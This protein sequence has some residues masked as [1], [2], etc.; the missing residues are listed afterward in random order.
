MAEGNDDAGFDGVGGELDGALIL[1]SDGD[2]LYQA[3]GGVL[4]LVE[5]LHGRRGQVRGVLGTLVLLGKE[6]AL[7]EDALDAGVRRIVA[8][9]DVLGDGGAGALELLGAGGERG[10]QVAGHAV[11]EDAAGN[12]RDALGLAIHDVGTVKAMDMRVDVAGGDLMTGVVD[13]LAVGLLGH[14]LAEHAVLDHQVAATRNAGGQ[15][16]GIGFNCIRA[17]VYS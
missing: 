16:E 12:R 9:L 14:I 6:G 13:D 11:A 2:L 1:G 8:R 3:M 15:V 7:E 17:H 4:P 10:G 5:L